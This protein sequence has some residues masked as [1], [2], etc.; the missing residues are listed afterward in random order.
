MRTELAPRFGVT[1]EKLREVSDM[2]D[3]AARK[4]ADEY[5]T[6]RAATLSAFAGVC[7]AQL[8][9][10]SRQATADLFDAIAAAVRN[11]PNCPDI[12]R[13]RVDRAAADLFEAEAKAAG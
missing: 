10:I 12:D 7:A 11:A 3:T 2:I 1:G 5:R 13:R 8:G 6:T 4:Q 9:A